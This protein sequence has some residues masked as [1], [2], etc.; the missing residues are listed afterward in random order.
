M[1][2]QKFAAAATF[3]A[4]L[5]SPAVVFAGANTG[6]ETAVRSYFAETPVMSAIASCESEFHQ[7]NTDGSVLHGGYKHRMIGIFQI[8]PLHLPTAKA[9]GF[10]VN[11]VAGNIAYAKYL[12]EREGTRPWLDSSWCWQKKMDAAAK[13]ES[14]KLVMLQKQIVQLTAVLNALIAAKNSS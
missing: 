4:L 14:A 1:H 2:I 5:F 8:A 10:D 6:V 11:T 12:Y 9:H 13:D 3:G 7:F